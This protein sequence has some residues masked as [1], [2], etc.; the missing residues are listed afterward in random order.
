MV[1]F[2]S[3]P[4]PERGSWVSEDVWAHE[5]AGGSSETTGDRSDLTH[6]LIGHTELLGFLERNFY[7]TLII[8]RNVSWAPKSAY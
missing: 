8:I 1:S 2:L 7:S 3:F 5:T 4:A 6:T